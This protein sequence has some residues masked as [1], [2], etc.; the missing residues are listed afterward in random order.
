MEFLQWSNPDADF[1]ARAYN[2][3]THDADAVRSFGVEWLHSRLCDRQ[4]HDRRLDTVLA[5]FQR[6]GLIEDEF[7][8]SNINITLPLPENL[9]DPEA[10][11]AKLQ[12]DQRRLYALVEYVQAEDRMQYLREYFA[13]ID[14]GR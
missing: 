1:Y 13:S 3:M 11:Q 6:Y 14:G 9:A 7:D 8:L 5:M 12:R 4:K 2:L 10:R